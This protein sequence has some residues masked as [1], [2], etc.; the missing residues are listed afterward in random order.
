MWA[1]Y[2]DVKYRNK[3][4][5]PLVF[6]ATFLKIPYNFLNPIRFDEPD[7]FCENDYFFEY[8]FLNDGSI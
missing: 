8:P 3:P 7:V 2:I 5:I 6:T 1:K 4:G